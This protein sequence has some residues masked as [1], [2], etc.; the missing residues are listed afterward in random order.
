MRYKVT[1]PARDKEGNL[2]YNE[3]TCG[4][5]F[6]RGVAHFDD[7]TL[8]PSL[9]RDAEETALIME[10]EFGYEV[11]RLNDDGTPYVA[12]EEPKAKKAKP[13]PETT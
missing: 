6:T 2:C 12:A 4:V 9:G 7:V 3:K 11:Q 5:Q 8:D 1:A 10:K 13:T